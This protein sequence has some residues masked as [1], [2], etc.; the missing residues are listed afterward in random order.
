MDARHTANRKRTAAFVAVVFALAC[1]ASAARAGDRV[2]TFETIPPPAAEETDDATR[3]ALLAAILL[4]PPPID[5]I[6]EM[7]QSQ[8][9]GTHTVVTNA[10]N[11][12]T[13]T[14]TT[15]GG[16][17]G[18]VHTETAPEPTTLVLGLLGSGLAAAGVWYRRRMAT[19]RAQE[20]NVTEATVAV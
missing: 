17:G 3:A 18:G 10:P 12:P 14:T 11:L 13:T 9:S 19:R 2:Q 4:I 16:G 8:P 20:S 15:G 6:K 7:P 5:I 1:I